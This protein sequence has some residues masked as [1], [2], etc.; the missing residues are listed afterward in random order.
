MLYSGA[1]ISVHINHLKSFRFVAWKWGI[2]IISK[3]FL[4][5]HAFT[6]YMIAFCCE[7][8][9]SEFDLF[10]GLTLMTTDRESNFKTFYF[11]IS[12]SMQYIFFFSFFSSRTAFTQKMRIGSDRSHHRTERVKIAWIFRQKMKSSISW[13]NEKFCN[14]A[15]LDGIICCVL[16]VIGIN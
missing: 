10:F 1:A 15:L 7:I 8:Y 11:Y 5:L 9:W 16:N 12:T 13:W 4:W 6:R 3:A 2:K 14:Y